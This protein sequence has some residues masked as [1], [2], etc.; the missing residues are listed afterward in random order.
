MR[1]SERSERIHQSEASE[2]F[3]QTVVLYKFTTKLEILPRRVTVRAMAK[4]STLRV[5][6]VRRLVDDVQGLYTSHTGPFEAEATP[7]ISFE[8]V[9]SEKERAVFSSAPKYH[10]WLRKALASAKENGFVIE[11]V[12]VKA[13]SLFGPNL[14]FA[15]VDATVRNTSTGKLVPGLVFLRGAA[16]AVLVIFRD[17]VSKKRFLVVTEQ[18]RVASGVMALAEACAGMMDASMQFRSVGTKELEEE[19]GIQILPTDLVLLHE[20]WLPSAGG[21]DEEIVMYY[22]EKEV[23]TSA[24]E[25]L[26]GRSGGN[27]VD[28]EF[29]ISRVVSYDEVLDNVFRVWDGK[30][31]LAVLL[32]ERAIRARA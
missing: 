17:S 14:G 19:L 32:Y 31:A 6:C 9:I 24:I 11:N 1:Q 30:L 16:V 15:Y 2:S 22:V 21:C 28:S 12:H 7:S 29:I 27:L 20:G 18:A 13:V 26:Q 23:E 10:A 25:K 5:R 8:S 4:V 3:S